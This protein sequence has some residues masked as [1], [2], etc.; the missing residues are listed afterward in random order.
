MS[1]RSHSICRVC[2]LMCPII[3]E[4]DGNRIEK[5]YGDKTNPVYFGYTCIKGR[6]QQDYLTSPERL[7][8]SVGRTASGAFEPLSSSAVIEQSAER[9]RSITDQYGPKSV[10]LYIGTQAAH[11]LITRNMALAWMEAIGSPMVFSSL[12]IDQPGK[13][14][15]PAL[16][17]IWLAG[18]YAPEEADV[19]LLVGT[20]PMVSMQGGLPINAAHGQKI[21]QRE[22]RKLIVIDPRKTESAKA[23]DVHLQ[24]LPGCDA[25]ILAAMI[26][27]IIAERLFDQDFVDQNASGFQTIERCVASF[28]LED[29][30]RRAG[31]RAADI[32]RAA[33]MLAQG[34]TGGVSLGTGP[35][36]SGQSNLSEYLGLCLMT[37]CGHWVRAGE[38]V[39]NPGVLVRRLDPIAQAFPPYPAWGFGEQLRV[40]GLGNSL[41][42]LPTSALADEILLDGERKIRALISL[43]GNPFSGWPDQQKTHEALNALDLLISVDPIIS[44]TG[45]YA[46]YVVAPKIFLEVAGNTALQESYGVFG[47]G[48]GYQAP[49]AQ[50]CGPLVDPPHGSDLIE[51]WE[52]FYGTAQKLGLPLKLKSASILD[53][54]QAARSALEVDMTVKPTT[55]RL[56]TAVLDGAPLPLSEIE[57]DAPGRLYDVDEQ[58]VK[59]KTPECTDRLRLD[60][61]TMLQELSGLVSGEW[62]MANPSPY[63]LITCRLPDIHN[64]SWHGVAA[65]KRRHGFNPLFVNPEDAKELDVTDGDFVDVESDHASITA[66]VQVSEDLRRRVVAL[67]PCWGA[68]PMGEQDP[69]TVGSSAAK[70]ITVDKHFDPITGIPRMSGVPV[71]LRK[72]KTDAKKPS[73]KESTYA[74]G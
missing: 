6:R 73:T 34:R 74:A 24:A 25:E 7:K 1:D 28:H 64:S 51:D 15:A 27:V 63:L 43:G 41:A 66:I 49:Y 71:R 9:I 18:P 67:P 23:A 30:A 62:N 26:R 38:K 61:P 53:Q 33:R 46:D 22:G 57:Q 4:R 8:H 52:F 35:N 72:L 59:P 70:L 56:W 58:F 16:H 14:I 50:A 42:G 37:L 12:T 3:V 54:K 21:R 2:H 10:A 48:W 19:W 36:M 32:E 68:P 65:L 31:L 39:R 29:V 13:V 60:D 47:P 11:N 17:G 20:N 55:D 5:I 44:T 40:K 45:K 69:Q